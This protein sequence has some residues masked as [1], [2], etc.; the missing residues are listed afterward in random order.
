MDG[1]TDRGR[2]VAVPRR[3]RSGLKLAEYSR[4]T[5]D[6]PEGGA[7]PNPGRARSR[8]THL[9]LGALLASSLF[10]AARVLQ[11]ERAE[12]DFESDP[13][14]VA[15]ARALPGATTISA[16]LAQVT[17]RAGDR[18]LFELCSQ[19]P[20]LPKLVR[21]QLEVAVL[22]LDPPELM[23]RV[24]L[25]EKRLA[26]ARTNDGG[27]CVELGGGLV[28]R[29]GAYS[30]DAVFD[31][32]TPSTA[33]LA[34]PLRVHV[35]ARMPLS[36]LDYALFAACALSVLGLLTAFLLH[37][38]SQATSPPLDRRPIPP[39]PWGAPLAA[40]V[41]LAA[42]S[43]VPLFGATLGFAKGVLLAL[44]E[45]GLA[46]SLT[47]GDRGSLGWIRPTYAVRA[48]L[49]ALAAAVLLSENARFWV[50]H[51]PGSGEAPIETFISWPSGLL[52]F[53]GLG[54]LLPIAEELFFRGYLVHAFRERL[55]RWGAGLLSLAAF[56]A[57]HVQQTY[58]HW[59]SLL[60]IAGT[61]LTLT[62][63]RLLTG[64]TL[65]PAVTHVLY[66]LVLSVRSL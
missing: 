22:R 36:R 15:A 33:S 45:V 39:R 56:I 1:S 40:L 35:L 19:E 16:R 20:R 31:G 44:A 34:V 66:N 2:Y 37:G 11:R 61:G 4:Q 52:A 3:L 30:I 10:L 5:L 55:G 51:W 63:L 65:V 32:V 7:A 24:A 64:S 29:G 58:G 12:L 57:L 38:P 23:L 42:L 41:A 46:L 49:L 6:A 62:V 18:V 21:D 47:G 13:L 25:D 50:R 14:N 59:G 28:Q 9:L 54:L 26:T 27:A 60:A 8:A 17:L 48:V 53:A 43:Q